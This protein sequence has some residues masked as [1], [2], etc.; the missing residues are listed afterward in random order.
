MMVYRIMFY[1]V[2]SIPFT[3]TVGRVW[4]KTSVC[5]RIS[6]YFLIHVI[7]KEAL[8]WFIC[9]GGTKNGIVFCDLHQDWFE[10]VAMYKTRMPSVKVM[11]KVQWEKIE[12]CDYF[13]QTSLFVN[14][15][16]AHRVIRR[17]REARR[18]GAVIFSFPKW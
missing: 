2:K 11:K 5:P 15:L 9:L 4:S 14:Q 16:E 8:L 6:D 3:I 12:L 17:V 18:P 7:F 10:F 1:H 13:G